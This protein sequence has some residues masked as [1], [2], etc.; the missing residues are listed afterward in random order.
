MYEDHNVKEQ[1]SA[2]KNCPLCYE[3]LPKYLDK[4]P[5]CKLSIHE[6]A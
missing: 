2:Y 4:C 6:E 3:R 1:K 5:T